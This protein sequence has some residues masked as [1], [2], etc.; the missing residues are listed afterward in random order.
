MFYLADMYESG[1]GV[2]KDL[3]QAL[4]WYRKAAEAAT[5]RA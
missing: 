5:E 4:Y 1:K 3:Q 2:K